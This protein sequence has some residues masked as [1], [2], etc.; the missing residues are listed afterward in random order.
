MKRMKI[1]IRRRT[2]CV[3]RTMRTR[4]PAALMLAIAAV[5]VTSRPRV[6]TNAR[7]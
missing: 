6:I 1:G 3:R 2:P 4:P 7:E 5:V